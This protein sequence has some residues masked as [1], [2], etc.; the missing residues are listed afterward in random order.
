[1]HLKKKTTAR[2]FFIHLLAMIALY[3][4][5]IS[6]L[7]IVFQVINLFIPDALEYDGT[8][9]KQSRMDMIRFSIS[10]LVV[11][12]PVYLGSMWF[13]QKDYTQHPEKRD[14]GIRKWLIYF[15]LFVAALIIICDCVSLMNSLLEG[16][17]KLRFI[18]KALSILFVSVSIFWYYFADLRRY[19]TE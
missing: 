17:L 5:A 9:L 14:L 1:M 4:S 6:F 16:E 12:F 15:T 3:A 10:T 13:L 2:D 8:Y 18:L 7:T 11:I 19:R